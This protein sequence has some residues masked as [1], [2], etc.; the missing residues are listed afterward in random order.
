MDIS[1]IIL[2]RPFQTRNADE[3]TDKNIADLFVD[4]TIGVAGP[5]DYGNEIV[6]GKMG[7]GKTMYLRANYTHYLFTLVPQMMSHESIILPLYIKLSDYQNIKNAEEIYKKLLIR[8]IQEILSTCDRIQSAKELV[9]LHTGVKN[10]YLDTWFSKTSQ[11]EILI[12]LNKLT[13]EEYVE[14]V[15]T[16][17][18]TQGTIGDTFIKACGTY[19]EK[20]FLELKRNTQVQIS[21]IVHAYN[22]LLKPIDAKLLLLFDEVGSIDKCFFEETNGGLSYFEILMNQLRTIDFIRTK[23]AIYPHTFAD[24]LTET[25]YGDIVTLEDEVYTP[26]GYDTFLLKT[27]SIA[28]K[29]LSSAAS[30]EISIEDVFDVQEGNMQLLEQIIYAS[31][32][33]MRRLVLLFN[34]ACNECYKRCYATEKVSIEDV[35]NAIQ[36]QAAEMQTLYHDTDLEFLQ[37]LVKVCKKRSAYRFRFPNKSPILLK[38]TNRSLEYNILKIKE[39]GTGRRGTTYWFDYAYCVYNDIPTHYQHDSEKIA[40]SRSSSEGDWITTITSINDELITQANIPGK[41]DGFI[42]YLNSSKTAGFITSDKK[43]DIFFSKDSVIESDRH[44]ILRNGLKVRFSP[45]PYGNTM[46]AYEIEIL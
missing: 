26:K 32:G 9:K 30:E 11:R 28:E 25:R 45:V 12:Q 37:N 19:G 4:P 15:C 21:D 8:L 35:I 23:I 44:K 38:Y 36:N 22:I 10:N 14:Q 13:A 16:E 29:Y 43:T 46:Y 34:S 42:S 1:E 17:L 6:K 20:E 2:K 40:R 7:T 41:N 33:N 3:F 31:D 27:I 39:V 5:F 18:T 24:M